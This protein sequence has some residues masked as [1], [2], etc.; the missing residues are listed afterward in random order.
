[1]HD[2]ALNSV[3]AVDVCTV[4]NAGTGNLPVAG[5]GDVGV[6]ADVLVVVT[7]G[8]ECQEVQQADQQ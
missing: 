6:S 7:A 4:F 2:D 8:G 3:V 1:M 5:D